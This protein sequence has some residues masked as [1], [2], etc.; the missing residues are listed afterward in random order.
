MCSIGGFLSSKPLPFR[1]AGGLAD[2]LLYY[3][4]ARGQQSAGVYV[5]GRI[6]KRAVSPDKLIAHT[7][8]NTL[9]KE[10]VTLCLTHTRQPTCGGRGDDQAQPFRAGGTVSVHNG[11][12]HDSKALAK[13][14]GIPKTSGVDSELVATYVH[15]KG[16]ETLGD[17]LDE[18][19]G[20]AAVAV[21]HKGQLYLARDSN[22]ISHIFI[23]MG[24]T[25]ILAFASTDDILMKAIRYVWLWP[26][27]SRPMSVPSGHVH[28]A[29]PKELTEVGSPFGRSIYGTGSGSWHYTGQSFIN[30]QAQSINAYR[31]MLI[32]QGYRI[33]GDGFVPPPPLV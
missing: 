19:T 27:T 17:F 5:D 29:T 33:E 28:L 9:F 7:D 31:S 2:A 23:K 6:V 24:D 16:I 8:Y 20:C 25:D 11:M 15:D 14:F 13:K 18:A 32:T 30:A 1:I 3:G 21:V 12:F 10:P 4:S 26:D 22:P